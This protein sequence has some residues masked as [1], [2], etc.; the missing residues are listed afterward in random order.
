MRYLFRAAHWCSKEL[1]RLRRQTTARTTAT[2]RSATKKK[3]CKPCISDPLQISLSL[4]G[5]QELDQRG[6]ELRFGQRGDVVPAL[7]GLEP[8]AAEQLSD[9][10][11]PLLQLD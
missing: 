4:V 11:N 8:A 9:R 1:D 6:R 3:A 5:A 10:R 2:T 7:D